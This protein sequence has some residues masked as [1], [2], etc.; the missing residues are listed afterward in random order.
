MLTRFKLGM[1]IISSSKFLT[2][3]GAVSLVGELAEKVVGE[4]WL[5]MKDVDEGN[6]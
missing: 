2:G 5:E 4:A 6:F 1:F 3:A